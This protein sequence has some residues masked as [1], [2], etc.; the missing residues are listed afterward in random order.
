MLREVIVP[1]S[2]AAVGLLGLATFEWGETE[3]IGM[4]VGATCLWGPFALAIALWL[5]E[6]VP[7]AGE[8]LALSLAG[9]YASTAVV[10]FGLSLGG[11]GW[12]FPWCQAA[13]V[14]AVV[15]CRSWRESIRT[16]L[17]RCGEWKW[18]W[19]LTALLV[20]TLVVSVRYRVPFTVSSVDGGRHFRLYHDQ[21]YH[22]AMTYELQRHIPP[23]Q[24]AMAAGTPERAYHLMPHISTLLLGAYGDQPDLLRTQTTWSFVAM[25]VM[26]CLCLHYTIR[27]VT[28]S[29]PAGWLAVSLLFIFSIPF[30]AIVTNPLGYFH[31]SL[32][33]HTTS[34]LE[35]VVFTTQQMYSGMVVLYGVFLGAA[36][37]DRLVRSD[38]PEQAW[39]I[40]AVM[41]IMTGAMLRFRAHAFLPLAP[42]FGLAGAWLA[43]RARDWRCLG[44][45]VLA[46]G[47]SLAL[48]LEIRSPT[49]AAGT[50]SAALGYNA[51]TWPGRPDAPNPRFQWWWVFWPGAAPC[52]AFLQRVLPEPVARQT[53]HVVCVAAFTLFQVVGLPLALAAAWATWHHARSRWP[54]LFG[55]ML[56]MTAGSLVCAMYI[57][58][59]DHTYDLAGQ[60]LLHIC[61]YLFP[62]L[63]VAAWS[64]LKS[65]ATTMTWKSRICERLALGAVLLGVVFQMIRPPS[66]LQ[67]VCDNM[68]FTL[69]ADEWE[70]FSFLRE[71]TP[72][73]AVVLMP[74][75]PLRLGPGGAAAA[76]RQL[77]S[78]I[79]NFSICGALGAR[80]VY[81]EYARGADLDRVQKIAQLWATA[82]VEDFARRLVDMNVDYMLEYPAAA[83]AAFRSD[84][85]GFLRLAWES[86]P[87]ANQVRI[88][89]IDRGLAAACVRNATT[90]IPLHDASGSKPP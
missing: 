15:A 64:G 90:R 1:A 54:L 30:P 6:S 7:D 27:A 78:E 69:S 5:R 86:R 39:R 23:V 40:V 29:S 82:D 63:P 4:A 52:L 55:L 53:W 84:V 57:D 73:G 68:G 72:T 28:G 24:R 41:G 26:L 42:A 2:I 25:T 62:M 81:A 38:R 74:I 37:L 14:A 32:Y 12:L 83:P 77:L 11:V 65:L 71:Q 18:D 85:P 16:A 89:K 46:A 47:I 13:A 59:G 76:E 9:S 44:G 10:Y 50:A 80:A 17:A 36:I 19:W 35:P 67:T 22:V 3:T 58:M 20:A 33:P 88:W 70:A 48:L 43:W 51:L 66:S 87:G 56:W 8:R 75:R 61:W 49:Y 79:A 31:C 45:V 34:L 21:T 60:M